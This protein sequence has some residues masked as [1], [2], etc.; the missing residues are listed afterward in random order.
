MACGTCDHTMHSVGYGIFHCPRCG[1]L[2]GVYCDG[3][4][5]APALVAKCR[6]FGAAL[7]RVA[8]AHRETLEL[9][10]HWLGL[11]L[12]DAIFTPGERRS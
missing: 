9:W 10:R 1:T 6:A 7:W 5:T 8:A 12:E 3:T 2:A 4:V 11:G